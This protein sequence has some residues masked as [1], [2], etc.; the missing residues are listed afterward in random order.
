MK[1]LDLL[2]EDDKFTK[3]IDN[4]YRYIKKG[5]VEVP[6]SESFHHR[7]TTSPS[8]LENK[9]VA[10]KYFL[11]DLYKVV[12]A[13]D[14]KSYK[15]HDWFNNAN[16]ICIPLIKIVCDEYPDLEKDRKFVREVVRSISRR[17]K[18]QFKIELMMS[19]LQFKYI[20]GKYS[21]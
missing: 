20:N 16:I 12:K 8:E 6:L 11:P 10:V 5:I 19:P 14:V 21:L 13:N 15:D 2:E 18:I 3:K 9:I 17:L 4:I 7:R 1:L